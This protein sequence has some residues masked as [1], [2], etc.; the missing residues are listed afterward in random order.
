MEA[1]QAIRIKYRQKELQKRSEVFGEFKK[2]ERFWMKECERTGEMFKPKI[3]F[4]KE[5]R[6]ENGETSL[7]LLSR[8]R[9]LLFKFPYQWNRMQQVR[10]K[11]LFSL[12]PE[13]EQVYHLSCQFRNFL[14]KKN[15]GQH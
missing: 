14:S 15:I 9:Y 5:Q 2:S 8:S 10:A 12:C 3:F 4:Y 6:L 7:E 11:V 1:H 13:I